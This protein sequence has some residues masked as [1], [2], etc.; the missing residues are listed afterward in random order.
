ML[1]VVASLV[2]IVAVAPSGAVHRA[3]AGDGH[4]PYAERTFF[5]YACRDDCAP[6]KAGFDWA[7]R[8]GI[9]DAAACTGLSAAV[10]EGCRAFA[11]EGMSPED[12]GYAWALEN[13]VAQPCHCEG[14]GGGFSAGCR[15]Y[16]MAP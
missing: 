3:C 13:E 15:R 1:P 8:H 2:L 5:G 16:V 6:Q 14:A 10:A 9:T 4:E 11:H 7:E 12:A